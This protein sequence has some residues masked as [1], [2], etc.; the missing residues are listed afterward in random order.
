MVKGKI[1]I[2]TRPSGSEDLIGKA[3]IKLG[4]IVLSMPLVEIFPISI[5]QNTLN[6]IKKPNTY[7]WLVF[8]SKNG[9]DI[10][11]DQFGL[12]QN[13]NQLPFKIAVFGERTATA[14]RRLGFEPD[15][16]NLKNSSVDLASDLYTKL[17][18]DYRVLLVIGDLASDLIEESLK[19]KVKV[20]RLNVYRTIFVQSIDNNILNLIVQNKYDL[21]LFT[22]PSGFRGF[23]HHANNQ[24]NLRSLKIACLGPTTEKT[25]LSEGITPL[26]VAKPSGRKGLI[27]GIESYFANQSLNELAEKR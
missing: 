18:N 2:N 10:F 8:T 3:L 13:T 9:V 11:F 5:S 23:L 4:A 12:P 22:S 19:S 27:N 16:V 21:I 1:I 7:Q 17:Q 14:L 20:D 6:K 24:I 25:I 26:V 15:L